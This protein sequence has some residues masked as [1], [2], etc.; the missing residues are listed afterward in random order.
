MYPD[1][2]LL[3]VRSAYYGLISHEASGEDLWMAV[4]RHNWQ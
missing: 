2:P 4:T 1:D 3:P